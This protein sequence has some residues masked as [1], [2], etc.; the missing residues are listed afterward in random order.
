MK[1]L[2]RV[3]TDLRGQITALRVQ[4]DDLRAEIYS[5]KQVIHADQIAISDIA[6]KVRSR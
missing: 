6:V 4:I 5:I 1:P 2:E 3:L